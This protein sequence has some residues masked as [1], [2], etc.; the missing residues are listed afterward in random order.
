MTLTAES[1]PTS[2]PTG[3]MADVAAFTA[4]DRPPLV[5]RED[6]LR[7]LLDAVTAAGEGRPAAVLL[8]GDAGVGKTRLLAQVVEDAP[9]PLLVVRGGCVDLGEVGLPYLPFVE[10]LTDL[11]RAVPTVADLPGLGPLLAGGTAVNDEVRRLQLFEAVAGALR[12]AAEQAPVLLVLEDLH[13]ADASSRELLRFLL[14][15]LRDERVAVLASYRADDLHRRHPLVPLVAEL[16]RLGGVE[17]LMLQPLGDDAVGRHVRAIGALPD[18]LVSLVVDRAEGNAYFA[19][20]LAQAALETG[21]RDLPTRLTD[22]LLARLSRLSEAALA[23]VRVAAVAGRRVDHELLAA[24][25]TQTGLALDEALREAVSAHVLEVGDGGAAGAYSFRHALLQETVYDDLL[26]GERVRLHGLLAAVLEGGSPGELAMHRERSGD[27]GGALAA[28]LEAGDAAMAA[29]APHEALA[30]RERALDLLAAGAGPDLSVQDRVDL[31]RGTAKAA[32][33]AG[34]WSRALAH[35]RAHVDV[36]QQLDERGLASAQ[37]LLVSHLLDADREDDAVHVATEA[38]AL[39]RKTGDAGLVA[40]AESLYARAVWSDLDRD[41]DVREAA[42]AAYEAALASGLTEVQSE[43]LTTLG[44]LAEAAGDR[45]TALVRYRQARDVAV[46][47]GH[48][49]EELRARYNVAANA[50]YAADLPTALRDAEEGVLRALDLGL[51]WTPYGYSL[52]MLRVVVR[53]VSGDF[54]GSSDAATSCLTGA[55]DLARESLLGVGLY[56][57]VARGDERAVAH[58]LRLTELPGLDAITLLVAAGTGSDG[59][60]MAGEPERAVAVAED[61]A[62]RLAQTWG[63]WSLGGIWLAALGIA[64]LADIA[65]AARDRHDRATAEAA[66]ARAE[67]WEQ[68]AQETARRGRPRGGALGPE[69]RAWLLRA[70]AELTRAQGAPDPALW[71]S[72]VAEFD[73]GYP[74]E[75][76]R[77]RLRLAEALLA[78]GERTDAAQELRAAHETAAQLPA[79]PLMAEVVALARRGRIDLP[80]VRR[81]GG[82]GALTPREV[83]VLRLVATG[84]TNRQVG[85][86]LFMSEKTASVHVSRIL[87]KLNASGRAE[88]A[89]RA[90]QLGLL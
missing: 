5:G 2:A 73:Y 11:V 79:E 52:R 78:L 70:T 22:V 10:A 16:S 60:R 84:L 55:V 71:R 58:A 74:Y 3:T 27:R 24:A 30:Y 15:R 53:Y 85:A 20:E 21:R 66:V 68:V 65:V 75:V 40:G 25:C 13:W 28:Y 47:G 83:E 87:T 82:P 12:L 18:D 86:Q 81:A 67:R 1:V 36:A 34:D 19:E 29:G 48:L 4:R 57:A 61:G 63:E 17:H 64:A 54:R 41:D 26:P 72:V 45:D 14:S 88:A 23:V 37:Q 77:S 80:G 69:G 76:A 6:E 44:G 9:R 31:L 56:T 89:A 33:L 62:R 49:M 90:A 50:F 43:A 42:E 51:G 39:A 7:L 38:R 35:A 32:K 46:E 8:G 59:L